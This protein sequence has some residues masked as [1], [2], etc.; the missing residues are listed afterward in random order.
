MDLH[1]SRLMKN[2]KYQILLN[3]PIIFVRV[4]IKFRLIFTVL[5]SIPVDRAFIKF[6][7]IFIMFTKQHC[8]SYLLT[9]ILPRIAIH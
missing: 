2:P 9:I 7:L 8:Y 3:F 4:V 1:L 5:D 6:R